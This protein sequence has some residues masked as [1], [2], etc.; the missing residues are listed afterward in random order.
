MGLD[1]A[2]GGHTPPLGE[3]AKSAKVRTK[4]R[5]LNHT[6]SQCLTPRKYRKWKGQIG[7]GGGG[8]GDT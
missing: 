8:G 7:G 5:V 6:M 2:V 1:I 3:S 4:E